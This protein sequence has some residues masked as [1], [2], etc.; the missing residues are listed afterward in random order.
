MT[1]DP[2]TDL[3]ER[4]IADIVRELGPLSLDQRIALACVLDRFARDVLALRD[5]QEPWGLIG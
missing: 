2:T 5:W 4:C 3:I 1:N